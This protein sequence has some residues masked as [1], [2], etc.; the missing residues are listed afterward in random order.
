[1]DRK[2]AIFAVA[3]SIVLVA[4]VGALVWRASSPSD[5]ERVAIANY[6]FS[7]SSLTIRAGTTVQW[8]NMDHVGHTVSFG[9]HG[10]MPGMGAGT[11]SGM[12][13]HMATFTYTFTEPGTYEYHCDPHPYMTA[14][15]V[16]TE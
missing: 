4:G 9:E 2:V 6:A 3:A 5:D 11:D 8:T 16:V 15:I 13:G 10:A 14:R 7:P 12:M 1:M